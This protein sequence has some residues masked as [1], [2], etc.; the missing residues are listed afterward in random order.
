MA[1]KKS[2][3][4]NNKFKKLGESV[5]I[6]FKKHSLAEFKR[7]MKVEQEHKDITKGNPTKT[8]KIVFAHLKESPTYYKALA[9]M[10]SKFKKKPS[11]S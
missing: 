10:E 2:S 9:T 4:I 5:G 6:D 11:N 8:A 1:L 3:I 7:G